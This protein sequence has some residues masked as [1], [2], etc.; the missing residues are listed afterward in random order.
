[1][2]AHHLT[3]N[4][5]RKIRWSG[6]FW[7]KK[8]SNMLLSWCYTSRGCSLFGKFLKTMFHVPLFK[9]EPL[10]ETLP[11]IE[12]L[13]C[14]LYV[15]RTVQLITLPKIPR[16]FVYP[17]HETHGGP[18]SRLAKRGKFLILHTIYSNSTAF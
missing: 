4:S 5:G 14:D 7:Y 1:M 10:I 18:N 12:I 13:W 8:S 17:F 15:K 2:H 11:Y 3:E 16:V 9:P 6:N